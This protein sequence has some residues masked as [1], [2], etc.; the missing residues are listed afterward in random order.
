MIRTEEGAVVGSI[1]R[2]ELGEEDDDEDLSSLKKTE[3]VERL[4]DSVDTTGQTKADLVAIVESLET[5]P[6][7]EPKP[8]RKTTNRKGER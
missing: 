2:A 7:P 4:P 6:E 8:V 3:L 1:D 5:A